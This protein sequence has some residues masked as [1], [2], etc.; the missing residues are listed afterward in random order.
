MPQTTNATDMLNRE[1]LEVRTRLL[2]IAAALDRIDRRTGATEAR[3]DQRY[4]Q[5][6]KALGLLCDGQANRAERV[7]KVFSDPYQPHGEANVEFRHEE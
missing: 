7:Q 3:S 5:V 2:D 4:S 6:A 1:F